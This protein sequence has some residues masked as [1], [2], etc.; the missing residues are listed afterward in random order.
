MGANAVDV[1]IE[2]HFFSPVGFGAG[3]QAQ[4]GVASGKSHIEPRACIA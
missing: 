3:W 1:L 2:I 4:G